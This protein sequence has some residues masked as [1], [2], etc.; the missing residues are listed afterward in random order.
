MRI[1]GLVCLFALVFV[2]LLRCAIFVGYATTWSA[3]P[4]ETH[5]TEAKVVHLAWR[6][7]FGVTLY[8]EWR[9]YPHVANFFSPVYFWLVGGIGRSLGSSLEQLFFAGRVV[10]VVSTLLASFA[11]FRHLS[12]VDQPRVALVGAVFSVGAAPMYGFAVMARPDV[13]AD[14]FGLSGYLLLIS[15]NRRTL[16]MVGLLFALAFLTKQTAGIYLLAAVATCLMQPR[17]RREFGRLFGWSAG[18]L[19]AT[20]IPLHLFEPHAISC[21][22]GEGAS[23]FSYEHCLQTWQHLLM[24][25]PDLPFFAIIGLINWWRKPQRNVDLFILTL[26]LLLFALVSVAKIGADQN[27]FLGLRSVE[28]LLVGNLFGSASIRLASRT[29]VLVLVI[30]SLMI[31]QGACH[32]FQRYVHARRLVHNL[33][34][35]Q[36]QDLLR[37]Y[38]EVVDLGNRTD[39]RLLTDTDVIALRQRDRAPFVDSFLFRLLVDTGRIE[40]RYLEQQIRDEAFDLLVLTSDLRLCEEQGYKETIFALPD[41]LARVARQ[42]YL[43]VGQHGGFSFY[44]PRS[45]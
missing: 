4:H 25:S 22:L 34:T 30:G 29:H 39:L 13:L 31:A 33:E 5:P 11:V 26:L 27:Y 43:L 20:L 35:S 41:R 2:G 24:S 10:T 45:R 9:E 3:Y 44:R 8:P 19:A 28:A 32:G 36:G 6:V 12:C 16:P 7:Q 17:R 21:L 38:F 18:G 40:P 42:R 37:R 1:V 14:T 15:W 23:P